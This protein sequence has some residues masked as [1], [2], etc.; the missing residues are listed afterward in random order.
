M[1][2]R[3]NQMHLQTVKKALEVEKARELARR[4]AAG[5]DA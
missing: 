3:L 5:D 4:S 2:I 1:T